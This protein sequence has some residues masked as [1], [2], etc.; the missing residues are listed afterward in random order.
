[1]NSSWPHGRGNIACTGGTDTHGR[2]V[3]ARI[4]EHCLPSAQHERDV[5]CAEATLRFARVAKHAVE[6]VYLQSVCLHRNLDVGLAVTTHGALMRPSQGPAH[7]GTVEV[8]ICH[9]R[10]SDVQGLP[11][12]EMGGRAA[13]VR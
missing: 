7:S 12:G 9:V 8:E 11:Q 5:V 10:S 1:M 2:H 6:A 4:F 3:L 13:L